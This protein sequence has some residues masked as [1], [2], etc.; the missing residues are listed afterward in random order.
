MNRLCEC[1][2]DTDP[3]RISACFEA[4][5][6][7]ALQL[8]TSSAAQ[9]I[10][11]LKRLQ[12]ALV[13]ARPALYQ[14]FVEDFGKP[15]LEVELTEILPV[16]EEI[17]HAIRHLR[18]W[19]RPRRVGM[20][21][22]SLG[23]AARIEYQPR[24]RCL[25]IGPW[26][27]P[28]ATV[29]APLVSAIG[30]GNTV[31]CKPSEYTPAVNAVLA[32]VLSAV[33]TADT[34]V[35]IEGGVATATALLALPFDH[36]FFT[37]SPAVG[38]IVMTAAARHLTSVTLE[39][40]GKSPAVVDES[41]DLERAA[42]LLLWG[43][44]INA[45]QSCIAP[46]HVFVHRRVREAFVEA[47][48]VIL[49][50]RHG[51]QTSDLARIIDHSHAERMA[52]L[53][54]DAQACGVPL[55]WGGQYDID[56]CHVAPTLFG[57]PINAARIGHEE[58]FGPLLPIIEFDHLEEV[59]AQINAGPKPLALYIWSQS[60]RVARRL[61]AVTSSGGACINHCMQQYTQCKLPF[62]GVNHSGM[63]SSHGIHGFRAFS[64]ERAVLTGGAFLPIRWLFAPYTPTRMK[65]ARCISMLA[66]RFG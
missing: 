24:G 56:R 49:V 61:L 33:F 4:Q 60:R 36:I 27:Y 55:L 1:V 12:K 52:E 46:D 25:I 35:L 30:A 43:K 62:G 40:G 13:A 44:L 53:I 31:I 6:G 63:G 29:I 21:I 5:K 20:T 15:E 37:G 17:A 32:Q 28:V 34:V 26:N 48:K 23:S 14:A 10:A 66:S 3:T 9:R 18:Q 59:V 54:E 65:L 50:A 11:S 41:A 2:P 19:M 8:R 39:L 47:C 42:E 64:H 51:A 7:R 58:I 57:A 45:G 38:R 16:L 22:T